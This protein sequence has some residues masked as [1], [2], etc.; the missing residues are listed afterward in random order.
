MQV[1]IGSG[2]CDHEI[3][4]NQLLEP[5]RHTSTSKNMQCQCLLRCVFTQLNVFSLMFRSLWSRSLSDI[6]GIKLFLMWFPDCLEAPLTSDQ[7]CG[8]MGSNNSNTFLW[9]CKVAYC[10]YLTLKV[11]THCKLSALNHLNV[12]FWC[13]C[14]ILMY[15]WLNK[16]LTVLLQHNGSKHIYVCIHMS[17]FI[18]MCLS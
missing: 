12:I 3:R 16:D 1:N 14:F 2:H 18:T 11:R 4:A 17:V 5:H 8:L 6:R 10:H 13:V 9:K 15:T 7:C